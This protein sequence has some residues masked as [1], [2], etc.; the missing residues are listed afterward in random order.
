M[1]TAMQQV[2]LKLVR[3]KNNDH[4]ADVK[5]VHRDI[6]LPSD[7]VVKY[8]DGVE[9]LISIRKGELKIDWNTHR[10]QVITVVNLTQRAPYQGPIEFTTELELPIVEP[11][12]KFK[13]I[14]T[15]GTYEVTV[16]DGG[17]YYAGGSRLAL[18]DGESKDTF[19]GCEYPVKGR[20][21]GTGEEVI[22]TT[23][24]HEVRGGHGEGNSSVSTV[25]ITSLDSMKP[26]PKET[27]LLVQGFVY[28]MEEVKEE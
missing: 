22:V 4:F 3:E 12:K 1:K 28:S 21:V 10:Y 13:Q 5:G 14:K 26:M 19:F 27:R 15:P 17:S 18:T 6:N 7:F 2:T 24:S 16:K 8:V 9:Y 25:Q 20:V 11:K 23:S